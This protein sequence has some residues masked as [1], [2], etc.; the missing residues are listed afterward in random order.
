MR[1]GDYIPVVEVVTVGG[2]MSVAA[3]TGTAWAGRVCRSC[4][5][6]E[7]VTEHQRQ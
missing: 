4:E 6:C 7:L 5:E 1:E 2:L 3:D